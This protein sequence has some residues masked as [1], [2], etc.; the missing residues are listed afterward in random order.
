M[1]SICKVLDDRL[2]S[3]NSYHDLIK[4][5]DDRPGHDL[6]YAIDS[7]R[8]TS[9]LGWKPR[10]SFESGLELTVDWYLANLDWCSTVIGRSGYSGQ[11]IGLKS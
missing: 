9:E 8:I 11:R 3:S 6:R 7:S 2:P 1:N 4:Q 10:H 5:V